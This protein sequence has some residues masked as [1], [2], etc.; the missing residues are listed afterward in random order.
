MGD[1]G[2]AEDAKAGAVVGSAGVALVDTDHGRLR[3]P[4]ACRLRIGWDFRG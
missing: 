3:W 1:A 4:Q 2:R